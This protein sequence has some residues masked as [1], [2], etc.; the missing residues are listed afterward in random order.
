MPACWVVFCFNVGYPQLKAM[1][2]GHLIPNQSLHTWIL[3]SI[4]W[5]MAIPFSHH[6]CFHLQSSA[7]IFV[8]HSVLRHSSVCR[9][10]TSLDI[11]RQ[12]DSSIVKNRLL[13][14][15]GVPV[16]TFSTRLLRGKSS[17]SSTSSDIMH[18]LCYLM[19]K[20]AVILSKPQ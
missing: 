11:M 19:R 12:L 1:H 14:F 2:S 8:H 4:P 5:K 17:S 10:S 6:Q 16:R 9:Q 7:N 18:F 15:L 20:H 3:A 13:D